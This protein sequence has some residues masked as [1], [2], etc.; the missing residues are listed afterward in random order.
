ME[1]PKATPKDFFLWAG[2]MISLYAGIFAFVSLLFQYI[3]HAF[4]DSLSYYYD[5]YQGGIA[6]SMA[7]LIVLAPLFLILMRAIRRSIERDPSRN[8]VWVRRWAL[9]L[10]V[11]VAGAA[12]VIDL[13]VLLTTFLSGE[14]LTVRFLLKVAVVLLV[15]AAGF[16]HFLADIWGYWL[17]NPHY[18]RYI[19]W[20]VGVL[21]VLSIA[22]GFLIVGSPQTQRQYRLDSQRV[23][24]LNSIQSQVI[25]VYQQK[26]ALPT[27]LSELEDPLSYYTAPTDPKTGAAYKYR[28][29]GPLSFEV[30]ATFDLPSSGMEE[31]MYPEPAYRSKGMDSKWIHGTGETCFQRVIDPEL[32]PPF[33]KNI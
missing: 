19:N 1:R 25:Y 22:A 13:I 8:E 23:Q 24:D 21:V 32:Y 16:M 5:P 9:Y 12:I 4:R 27:A 6:Y 2:A 28:A 7:S 33:T 14:E 15:A 18:A 10:F 17:K 3:N 30:C 11:F 31:P 26:N 20:S 29:T